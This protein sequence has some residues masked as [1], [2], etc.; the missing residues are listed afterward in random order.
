MSTLTL[1]ARFLAGGVLTGLVGVA[2]TAGAAAQRHEAP[3]DFSS[4][5]VGWIAVGGDFMPVPGGPGLI[6]D[7]PAHPYVPN[8]IGAQPT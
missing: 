6:R 2:L 5:Q 3:P 7:D 4:N 8:N 1:K